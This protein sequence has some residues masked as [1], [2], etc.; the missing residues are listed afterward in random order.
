MPPPVDQ[1]DVVK[2]AEA[3][4]E[5]ARQLAAAVQA[6]SLGKP[7]EDDLRRALGLAAQKI[8][9]ETL[10]PVDVAKS[11]FIVVSDV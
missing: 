3:L 6:G 11:E 8:A 5:S 1:F 2:A 4:L 7:A 10:P 9:S